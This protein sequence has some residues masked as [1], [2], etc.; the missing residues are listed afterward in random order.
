[1]L[2]TLV[3]VP[4]IETQDLTKIYP[5]GDT[6]VRALDGVSLRIEAGEYVAIM[7][8][9]G[10]GKTTLLDILGCLSRP[11][12]GAYRLKGRPVDGLGGEE[13]ARIR[14][15]EFGFVFQNF[16]L[17]P[18]ATAQANVE[19][20]L[21]YA[22]I[23]RRD[24]TRRAEEALEAVGLAD[25]RGHRPSELSGGQRQRVAIARALV[26]NPLILFADEPTGNLDSK[27]GAGI[28]E[29]FDGLHAQGHTLV[30]VTHEA[31]VA[32]RAQRC[33]QFRDG[34]IVSDERTNGTA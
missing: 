11:T 2:E 20:P 32:A 24:R 16:N 26:N 9:S 22:G 18:R 23:S 3:A 19:L 28:L 7:G 33:V 31:E 21:M 1:V 34:R 13:L 29:L 10:S 27:S 5:M 12:S 6:A 30:L 25:R 15:A 4:L 17:L 8:T 14:N